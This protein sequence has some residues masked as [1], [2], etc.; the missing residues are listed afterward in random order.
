MGVFVGQGEPFRWLHHVHRPVARNR[1]EP[2]RN[3]P[4][5]LRPCGRLSI[6]SAAS[7]TVI[8]PPDTRRP[9]ARIAAGAPASRSQRLA[10]SG[11]GDSH[12]GRRRVR[13]APRS[14]WHVAQS[15]LSTGRTDHAIDTTKQRK[16][17]GNEARSVSF[18]H[19]GAAPI[20]QARG[21]VRCPCGLPPP[22]PKGTYRRRACC[23]I[24]TWRR[25][26]D[27]ASVRRHDG[28]SRHGGHAPSSRAALAPRWT[29]S[30]S[31]VPLAA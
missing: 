12:R 18:P 4:A 11:Q 1:R 26:A 17:S 20:A 2:C 21:P 13:V 3:M 29:A 6:A 30:R 28:I 7:R 8:R 16:F 5:A 19:T 10:V 22:G 14:G 27:L 24:D 15:R 31:A 25:S 9:I 23:P